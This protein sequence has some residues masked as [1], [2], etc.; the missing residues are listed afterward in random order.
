MAMMMMVEE[1]TCVSGAGY[2]GGGDDRKDDG[3]DFHF[4]L[5]RRHGARRAYA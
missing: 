5:P 3:P 4:S 2:D 1:R